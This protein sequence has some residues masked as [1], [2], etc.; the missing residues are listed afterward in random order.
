[1]SFWI[2]NAEPV[3]TA[4]PRCSTVFFLLT[5]LSRARVGLRQA[6]T[7]LFIYLFAHG[8]ICGI[9]FVPLGH[10]GRNWLSC[11]DHDW[12]VYDA[13]AHCVSA[14]ISPCCQSVMTP[15]WLMQPRG[16]E[17]NTKK[18]NYWLYH[19]G[20]KQTAFILRLAFR[21]L[22]HRVLRNHYNYTV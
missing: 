12:R 4:F 18:I 21:S 14:H 15:Q 19:F 8:S 20:E 9:S 16:M 13:T 1:M 2:N 17:K 11:A 6:C 10:N 5:L 22:S 3:L 7:Y